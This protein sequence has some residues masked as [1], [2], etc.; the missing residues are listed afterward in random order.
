MH[1][2]IVYI[3]SVGC[4]FVYRTGVHLKID[5]GIWGYLKHMKAKLFLNLSLLCPVARNVDIYSLS[6]F[7]QFSRVLATQ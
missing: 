4:Y 1:V 3:K 2:D 6:H 7:A 5:L